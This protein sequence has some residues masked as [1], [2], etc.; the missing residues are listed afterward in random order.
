MSARSVPSHAVTLRPVSLS[1]SRPL[2]TRVE[3]RAPR[4]APKG[5]TTVA[6]PRTAVCGIADCIH[7]V[8]TI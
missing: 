6:S 2:L 4:Q 7:A 5:S 1:S 8:G 3:A